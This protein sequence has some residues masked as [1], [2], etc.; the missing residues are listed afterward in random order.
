MI[1]LVTDDSSHLL[2]IVADSDICKA[3]AEGVELDEPIE[4]IMNTHP[5]VGYDDQSF[6]EHRATMRA[7]SIY[8]LPILDRDHKIVGL[9]MLDDTIHP[10]QR[11][12]TAVIMAGG[13]GNRLRPL[14]DNCPKPLLKVGKR[15]ILETILLQLKRQGFRR[16]LI[17]VNYLG[18]MVQSEIGDGSKFGLEI[19]YLKESKRLGTAGAL[20]NIPASYR[21]EP[22]LVMNGDILSHM[23]YS[24]LVDFHRE[25]DAD[26]TIVAREQLSGRSLW[27][28]L[29]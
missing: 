3:I 15:R 5:I 2:G 22:L 24:N 9:R 25:Q 21:N 6:T 8:Q 20:A 23:S 11:T 10:M 14:T 1:A 18:E 12:T 16:V 17:S 27:C 26:V 19:E 28:G 4:S 13:L 7:K 29:F